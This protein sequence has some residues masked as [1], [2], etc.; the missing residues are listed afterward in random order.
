[1]HV[2]NVHVED[3][4]RD[5]RQMLTYHISDLHHCVRH[6]QFTYSVHIHSLWRKEEVSGF[7]LHLVSLPNSK[8]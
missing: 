3:P 7:H 2:H 1:M 4:L 6:G 5:T 8:N